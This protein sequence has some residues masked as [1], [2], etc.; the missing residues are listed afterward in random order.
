MKSSCVGAQVLT[1][2][3]HTESN[4]RS[5]PRQVYP[6]FLPAFPALCNASDPHQR[7]VYFSCGYYSVVDINNVTRQ[8]SSGWIATHDVLAT[9][10][11]S[12]KPEMSFL[13]VWKWP[14]LTLLLM[15]VMFILSINWFHRLHCFK[16]QELLFTVHTQELC[17]HIECVSRCDET[18]RQK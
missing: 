18:P 4:E 14:L 7:E 9:L 15:I 10:T 17:P 3:V 16:Q 11:S 1:L 2:G 12:C 8:L 5:K 6:I 13:M